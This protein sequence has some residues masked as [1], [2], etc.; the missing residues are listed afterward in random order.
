[1][2]KSILNLEGVSGLSRNQQKN[3]IGGIGSVQE[4][5]DPIACYETP[6][7]KCTSDTEC[8]AKHPRSYCF[9]HACL[10]NGQRV[11]FRSC[12]FVYDGA[13]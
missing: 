10:F 5:E 11:E 13:I 3:I 6:T 9:L 7:N 2:K 12:Q 1:M 8:K 4:I